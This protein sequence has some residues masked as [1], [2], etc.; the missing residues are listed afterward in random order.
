MVSIK[1]PYIEAGEMA[2]LVKGFPH[3]CC[4][5]NVDLQHPCTKIHAHL[6]SEHWR[7]QDKLTLGTC[8]PANLVGS[9]SFRFKERFCLKDKM[10]CVYGRHLILTSDHHTHAHTNACTH[11]HESCLYIYINSLESNYVSHISCLND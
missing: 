7:I 1:Y 11:K 4:D 2:Q 9:V 5:V 6:Q 10:E 8:G 3:T